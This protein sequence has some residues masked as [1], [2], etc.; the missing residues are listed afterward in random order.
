MNP[1]EDD[2]RGALRLLEQRAPDTAPDVRASTV[3]TR[4]GRETVLRLVS[5]AA[6]VL[7]IAAGAAVLGL[8]RGNTQ[9]TQRDGATTGAP[10]EPPRSQAAALATLH[11][12]VA[13]FGGP[14]RPSGGGEALS[15]SPDPGARVSVVS[16]G[17]GQ[18]A[19]QSK[20]QITSTTNRHGIAT[21]SVA[22][23]RYRYRSGVCG[24]GFGHHA[25]VTLRAGQ[26]GSVRIRCAVP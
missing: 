20:L 11:V 4:P 25:P 8:H 5:V 21:F 14:A 10:H 2:L 18:G 3:R 15:N 24:S 12:R 26:T 9:P 16:V 19:Y 7:A 23:G 1:T 6:L 22:P 13:L 17:N